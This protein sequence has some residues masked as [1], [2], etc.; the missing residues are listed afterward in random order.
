[1]K[2]RRIVIAATALAALGAGLV[3]CSSPAAEDSGSSASGGKPFSFVVVL[4][5]TGPLAVNAQQQ[6]NGLK[7]SA[8]ELNA[9]GGIGGRQVVFKVVDDKADPTQAVT[10]LQDQIN[11]DT[12]PDL[13]W[14]GATSGE[15]LAMAPILTNAGIVS[16]AI[17][18]SLLLNDPTKYPYHFGFTTANNQNYPDLVEEAKSEGAK[19]IGFI[20]GNDA[21]G[22][23]NLKVIKEAA[24]AARMPLTY[25]TFDATATDLTGPM[26]ALRATKPD[27]LVLSSYGAGAGYLLEARDK[28]G[29]NIPTIGDLAISASNPAKVVDPKALV[30]IKVQER[31]VDVLSLKSDWLPAEEHALK[32]IKEQGPIGGAAAVQ[33]LTAYDALQIVGAAAAQEGG[34]SASQLKSGMEKLKAPNPIP[35]TMYKTYGFTPKNH[36]PVLGKNSLV[37][38]PAGPS[39]D[40]FYK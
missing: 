14:A 3:G 12:P 24:A 37:Y 33:S 25:E 4:P 32:L 13:V 19:S 38:V 40:G 17:S 7:A 2:T 28:L 18:S 29:W 39:Q 1:M 6:L 10:L 20:T 34:T 36:F 11:S 35:W 8:K 27:I 30:G 5:L 23:D 15:A 22:T 31:P 21:L 26:D 9:A 16:G